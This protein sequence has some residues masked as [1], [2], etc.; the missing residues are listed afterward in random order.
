M[1]HNNVILNK[2]DGTSRGGI[3]LSVVDKFKISISHLG[4]GEGVDD[5]I[6]LVVQINGKKRAVI[7]TK[8]DIDEKMLMNQLK[9]ESKIN[10]NFEN[11][12][13]NKVFFVKNRLIN[14]LLG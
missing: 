3:A 11:K 14:I 8:K 1:A 12:R 2:M 10:K 4:I 7:K 9:K 13:I 6:E 5:F